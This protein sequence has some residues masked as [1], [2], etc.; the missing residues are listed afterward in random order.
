MEILKKKHKLVNKIRNKNKIK[1][2]I[3]IKQDLIFITP[4]FTQYYENY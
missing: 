2:K 3:N 1:S 4:M